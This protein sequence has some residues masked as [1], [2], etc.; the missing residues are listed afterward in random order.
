MLTKDNVLWYN[1]YIENK[2]RGYYGFDTVSIKN[3]C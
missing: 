3:V 1:M 2:G